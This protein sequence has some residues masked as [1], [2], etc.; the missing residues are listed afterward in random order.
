MQFSK[1]TPPAVVDILEQYK[2]NKHTGLRLH[3]GDRETGTVRAEARPVR[4][5]VVEDGELFK[6]PGLAPTWRGKQ[7]RPIRTAEIVGI[8]RVRDKKWLYA[9]PLINWRGLRMK[10]EG[11]FQDD[12]FV[13]ST[14]S[15]NETKLKR[16]IDC[17]YGNRMEV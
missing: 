6:F 11:L 9:H 13:A 14:E 1:E 15:F 2:N 4:G 16:L 12:R 5:Y 8:Q 3:Y 10:K 17:I 7:G